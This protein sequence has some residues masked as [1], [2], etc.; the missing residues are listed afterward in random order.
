MKTPK[1][2]HS[3]PY[4][5]QQYINWLEQ[6]FKELEVSVIILDTAIEGR[7]K[8]IKELEDFLTMNEALADFEE[9]KQTLKK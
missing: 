1:N 8:Q 6:Q 9:Y 7:D 2:I 5:I 4:E 3:Q